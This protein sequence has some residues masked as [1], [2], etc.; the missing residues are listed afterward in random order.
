M[1]G[2]LQY[3]YFGR[4]GPSLI[5]FFKFSVFIAWPAS[6]GLALAARAFWQLSRVFERASF[7][8][9]D[10]PLPLYSP[11]WLSYKPF[12]LFC[13]K[14]NQSVPL[15]LSLSVSI[16]VYINLVSRASSDNI[17]STMIICL[18]N[19]SSRIFTI[20]RSSTSAW[21][22]QSTK[23]PRQITVAGWWSKYCTPTTIVDKTR[24]YEEF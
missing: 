1:Y 23:F 8:I 9:K 18:Q 11:S 4:G 12:L 24:P 21:R 22:S 5:F 17:F 3:W 14:I 7:G 20:W 10:A 6:Q 16:L 2:T 15:S 19:I 13:W